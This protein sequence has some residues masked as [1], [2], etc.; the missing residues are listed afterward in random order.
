MQNRNDFFSQ[1]Q[2]FSNFVHDILEATNE[3]RE[4]PKATASLQR[5]LHGTIAS[6]SGKISY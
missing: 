6:I 5:V 1:F 2:R 3:V 4:Q